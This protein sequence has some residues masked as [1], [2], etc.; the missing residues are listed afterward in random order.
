MTEVK[1]MVEE[2]NKV[3]AKNLADNLI[4]KLLDGKWHITT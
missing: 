1:W 4:E 3:I 2:T